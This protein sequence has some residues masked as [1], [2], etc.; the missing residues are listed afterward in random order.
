MEVMRE[1]DASSLSSSGIMCGVVPGMV[2]GTSPGKVPDIKGEVVRLDCSRS[3]ALRRW[4]SAG[5]VSS[6]S[7]SSLY[8]D[9]KVGE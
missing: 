6:S 8:C 9:I 4:T 5:G 7:E 1:D 2:S 3:L